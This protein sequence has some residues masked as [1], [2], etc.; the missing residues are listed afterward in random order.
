LR[1]VASKAG[2]SAMYLS[3]LERDECEPRSEVLDALANAL[4]EQ[5]EIL[6]V[7]AGRVHSTLVRT[8]MRH[9]A[10]WVGLLKAG[11]NASS[12]QLRGLQALVGGAAGIS[13]T[14]ALLDT[15]KTVENKRGVEK[16][17]SAVT[18]ILTEKSA[19]P[20]DVG[21]A[22]LPPS[23]RSAITAIKAA[24]VTPKDAAKQDY[25]APDKG[26]LVV[27]ELGHAQD[28]ATDKNLRAAAEGPEYGFWLIVHLAKGPSVSF[29]AV[30]QIMETELGSDSK[31]I[32]IDRP[33]TIKQLK[34]IL[35]ENDVVN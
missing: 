25:T 20:P 30:K 10:E 8:M 6:F 16:P 33:E 4:G 27:H 12:A 31:T 17:L 24:S 28:L 13:R 21:P 23:V 7:K 26:L 18:K 1:D 5:A 14:L 22:Y 2:I 34:E 3:L 9:P 11:E 29:K 32:L 15:I 35:D 19:P